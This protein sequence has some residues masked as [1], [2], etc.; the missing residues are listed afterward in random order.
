MDKRLHER[1]GTVADVTVTDIV[2]PE[3]VAT[4]QIVNV[5]E[6]GVCAHL[7]RRFAPGTMI[8]AQL[9]DGVLFGHVIYSHKERPF[10]TGIEVVRVL[11]G[12]SD[13]ARL[14]KSVIQAENA[15][16]MV[17]DSPQ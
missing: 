13:L 1:Y 3:R 4:G 7:S 6:S 10:Q 5:S 9:A 2:N 17:A 15:P 11:I 8:K 12:E 14:V 16:D